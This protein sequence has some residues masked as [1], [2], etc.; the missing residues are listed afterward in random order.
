MPPA[1]CSQARSRGRHGRSGRLVG[2]AQALSFPMRLL[3]NGQFATVEQNS[4]AGDREGVVQLALTRPGERPLHPG[5]GMPDPTF[6]GFEVTE[7]A[8]GLAI[9]GPPVTPTLVEIVAESPNVQR[10]HIEFE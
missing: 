2:V 5:F 4:D 3:A 8:A 9:Y 7:L 1:C 10:V 6:A